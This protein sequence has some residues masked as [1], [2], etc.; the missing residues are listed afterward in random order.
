MILIT[1]R[2]TWGHKEGAGHAEGHTGAQHE[3]ADARLVL[4]SC[5][6]STFLL[7]LTIHSV[8]QSL[9]Q[10]QWQLH[11]SCC[12]SFSSWLSSNL[13]LGFFMCTHTWFERDDFQIKLMCSV[14]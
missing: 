8:C 6:P 5:K 3:Q 11:G 12:P 9:Q 7:C 13:C 10:I 14:I 4:L 2:E 1:D